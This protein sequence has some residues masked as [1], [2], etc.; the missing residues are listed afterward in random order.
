MTA[1]NRDVKASAV[2]EFS[3]LLRSASLSSK[4][5]DGERGG[6]PNTEATGNSWF[7][8]K[9]SD[10]EPVGIRRAYSQSDTAAS[11]SNERP[12]M[13]TKRIE[14]QE[15]RRGECGGWEKFDVIAD[16]EEADETGWAFYEKTS[17]DVRWIRIPPTLCRL[18]RVLI[19]DDEDESRVE[20]ANRIH[21]PVERTRQPDRRRF[22]QHAKHR[23]R[24]CAPAMRSPVRV[25][26]VRLDRRMGHASPSKHARRSLGDAA[27]KVL[28]GIASTSNSSDLEFAS[29]DNEVQP[30]SHRR[31]VFPGGF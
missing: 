17:W 21:A 15:P 18:A 26:Q 10:R 3:A 27:K 28:I 12:N 16:R 1:Q 23:C 24:L 2:R 14:W 20:Y 6:S 13:K 25:P 4:H 31:R 11:R 29:T 8:P 9:L 19:L 5:P 30:P 22:D 7:M